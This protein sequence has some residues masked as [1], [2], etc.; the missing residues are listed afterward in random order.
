MRNL[1]TW[2]RLRVLGR[3]TVTTNTHHSGPHIVTRV[4][5]SYTF[6]MRP[7]ARRDSR[8]M[9][10]Y[11]LKMFAAF[12]LGLFLIVQ[13]SHLAADGHPWLACLLGIAVSGLFFYM[14]AESVKAEREAGKK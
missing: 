11:L 4:V 9:M 3:V 2:V 10:R 6:E 8:P 14:A 13:A 1:L 7:F 12:A 5:D